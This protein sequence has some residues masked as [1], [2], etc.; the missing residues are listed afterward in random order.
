MYN[1]KPL[2]R[3]QATSERLPNNTTVP[4]SVWSQR[5]KEKLISSE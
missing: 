3:V 4:S 2:K 1:A 5:L